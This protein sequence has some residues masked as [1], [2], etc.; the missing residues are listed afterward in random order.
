MFVAEVH[1]CS[2]VSKDQFEDGQGFWRATPLI[3]ANSEDRPPFGVDLVYVLWS[4]QALE[5]V[6]HPVDVAV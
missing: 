3:N 6:R 2:S 1:I 4:L 5:P